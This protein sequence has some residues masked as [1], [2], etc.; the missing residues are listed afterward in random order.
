D[1]AKSRIVELQRQHDNLQRIEAE[2]AGEL[3]TTVE[4]FTALVAADLPFLSQERLR[5]VDFL[6]Q[7]VADY[8]LVSAEKLRRVLEG[9]QVELGY[10][11]NVEINDGTITVNGGQQLVQF[12]RPGRLGLY[13]LATD[14]ARAWI[15]ER[16]SGYRELATADTEVVK[17]TVEMVAKRSITALSNL[18]V[19]LP[20]EA[21][22]D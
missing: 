10:G 7:T 1:S 22:D 19:A 2:L 9:L 14:G 18:P 3:I 21:S 8:E 4:S 15:W 16:D 5:R 11:N 13:A 20:V 17:E 6:Q 12:F